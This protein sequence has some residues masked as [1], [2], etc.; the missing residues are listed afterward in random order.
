MMGVM[1]TKRPTT[2]EE[3]A[4]AI[5]HGIGA[6]LSLVGLIVMV[7]IAALRGDGWRVVACA[8]YGTT[9][10]LLYLASTMYH[11]LTNRRAKRVFEILDHSAIYLLIAGTYTP[12]TLVVLRG[13][14]G[15]TLFGITWGLAAMGILFKVFFVGR[16]VAL[17]T[18]TY[19]AMGWVMMI[20]LKPLL[21]VISLATFGWILAGGVAYTLGVV[22]FLWPRRYMHAV[23]HLFVLAG[24]ICHFY[25]VYRSVLS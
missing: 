24:S 20:A 12:F 18:S 3:I 22:F 17:S 9:L 10:L 4:N 16:M 11:A 2:G 6:V 13:G 15:W 19:V 14:W 8:V 5:T 25:A 1:T 21:S 23:W 7:V